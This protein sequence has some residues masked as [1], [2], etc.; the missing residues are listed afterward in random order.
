M[1]R[2][3]SCFISQPL[4]TKVWENKSDICAQKISLASFNAVSSSGLVRGDLATK[5][6]CHYKKL[7]QLLKCSNILEER[8]RKFKSERDIALCYG[9][10]HSI[11]HKAVSCQKRSE[12][13]PFCMHHKWYNCQGNFKMLFLKV[14]VKNI[15]DGLLYHKKNNRD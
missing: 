12:N 13:P 4:R 2:I 1:L 9:K 15:P 14:K 11:F 5:Q 10:W 8:V 7:Q 3:F 6:Y